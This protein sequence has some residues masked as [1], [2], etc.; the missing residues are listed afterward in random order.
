MDCGSFQSEL[1]HSSSIYSLVQSL[2][3]KKRDRYRKHPGEE[4]LAAGLSFDAARRIRRQTNGLRSDPRRIY[5]LKG[6]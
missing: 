1:Y 5:N 6:H 3:I 2:R 4:D